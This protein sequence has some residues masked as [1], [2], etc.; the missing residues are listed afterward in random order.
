[1]MRRA[2]K[3]TVTVRE[4]DRTKCKF[5]TSPN[6][7]HKGRR[8][9]KH[10]EFQQWGCRDCGRR[11]THNIGFEKKRATPEQITMAIA[12]LFSGLSSR[13]TAKSLEILG[14]KTSHITVQNWAKEYGALME[15]YLDKITP[16]VGETWATDELY[17]KIK[18]NR[19]YLFAILDTDTKFWLAKM[20]AEHKGTDDVSPMFQEAAILANKKPRTTKSD[21]A[22]NFHQAWKK[23]YRAPNALHKT[24]RHE[25]HIHLAGDMNNN[26]QEAFNGATVRHREKVTRSLKNEDSAILSG[27]RT[28]HNFIKPHLGLGGKTPG[29]AAGIMINGTN[30]WL[31]I[32]QNAIEADSGHKDSSKQAQVTNFP[33]KSG[34]Q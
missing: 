7:I 6:I 12:L 2:V 31:T 5:C 30:K 11:F 9:L 25:R 3:E 13:K 10:G 16:Q 27:L 17:L 1:M 19:R 28:Y 26:A 24:T 18:G 15:R 32:V 23:E 4:I 34:S 33:V 21:G 14:H 20:V 22:A 8:K 29:E